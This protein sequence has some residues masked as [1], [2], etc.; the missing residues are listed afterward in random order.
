MSFSAEQF[1][2]L[3]RYLTRQG[4]DPTG[5]R[6]VQRWPVTTR[7][8]VARAGVSNNLPDLVAVRDIS[9]RGASLLM[10][11]PPVHG[12]QMVL[13]LPRRKGPSLVLISEVRHLQRLDNQTT[14]VGI[15]F[16]CVR[17]ARPTDNDPLLA[18]LIAAAV[19]ASPTLR[20]TRKAA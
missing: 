6:R 3:C 15:E 14:A 1:E 8:A 5:R 7:A 4:H 18:R 11:E 9:P 2:R 20:S 17:A 13:V 16:V 12:E 10:S 19:L